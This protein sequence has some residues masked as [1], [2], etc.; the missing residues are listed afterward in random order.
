LLLSARID[1][2]VS[3]KATLLEKIKIKTSVIT[4]I[5]FLQ[6]IFLSNLI[7]AKLLLLMIGCGCNKKCGAAEG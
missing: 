4:R 7:P 6:F 2:E 1:F 3:Q 5:I